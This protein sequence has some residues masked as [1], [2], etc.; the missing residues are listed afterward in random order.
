MRALILAA[1]RGSRLGDLTKEK[2]KCLMNLA[3][4]TLLEWQ[5]VALRQS[6][7]ADIAIV[8]GYKGELLEFAKV[9]FLE[10][11]EWMNTNMVSSLLC[12]SDWLRKEECII[13]Y[14]DIVYPAS[15]IAALSFSKADL[16]ISYNVQWLD[17]WKLRFEDPLNDAET[18]RVN[19]AGNVTEIG[20]KT[21]RLD[22]IKGQY[23]GLLK[24]T[25]RGWH[26]IETYLMSLTVEEV[27]K[28]DMTSL[29]SRLINRGIQIKGIPINGMWYEVDNQTD[30]NIYSSLI[31]SGS[32]WMNEMIK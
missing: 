7:V 18:F 24:F 5:L 4:K 9:T 25:P 27:K 6:G 17:T 21:N 15:T 12:A 22:D 30:L 1:G 3:G 8:R 20:G 23:M 19:Q 10:N 13:S 32:S 31:A 2:P 16:C 28:L 11:N 29:L 26:Q 14:S